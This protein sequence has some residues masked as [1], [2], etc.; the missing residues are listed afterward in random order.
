MSN[1]S[2]LDLI[3]VIPKYFK[4]SNKIFFPCLLSPLKR[5]MSSPG[6]DWGNGKF[7]FLPASSNSCKSISRNHYP[8]LILWVSGVI[9]NVGRNDFDQLEWQSFGHNV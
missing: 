3:R 5:S 6:Y 1:V 9:R 4:T 8:S 2:I 7:Q